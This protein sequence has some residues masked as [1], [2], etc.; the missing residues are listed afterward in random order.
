M[1]Q[2]DVL[3]TQIGENLRFY[4]DMRFKQ[5]TLLMAWLTL[6]GAGVVERGTLELIPSVP[7]RVIIACVSML[8]TAVLW[9]M[10]VRATLYW[11]THHRAIG[12]ELC[13]E[14]EKPFWG[15]LRATNVVLF[16][17]AGV[18]IL[19][20]LLGLAWGLPLLCGE[21]FRIVWGALFGTVWIALIV[22]SVVN[23]RRSLAPEGKIP[24]RS[25][26]KK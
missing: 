20:V 9:V 2:D 17:Y 10:E 6:A 12:R 26:E 25:A 23:Y 24:E 16:V 21:L 11:R 22:F 7:V 5:L 15:L 13:P 18:Y 19:W 1:P 14:P 4:G 3:K 8:F